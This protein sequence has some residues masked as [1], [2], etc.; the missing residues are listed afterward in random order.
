VISAGGLRVAVS[1]SFG[2]S[3]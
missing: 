2:I 3:K 1:R